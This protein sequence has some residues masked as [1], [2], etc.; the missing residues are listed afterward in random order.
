M[1]GDLD[2]ALVGLDQLANRLVLGLVQSHLDAAKLDGIFGAQLI[3]VGLDVGDRHR[4][5][6]F[7]LLRGEA[8]GAIPERRARA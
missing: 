3:L 2:A 4:H 7:E 1:L 5:G 8:H 6:R